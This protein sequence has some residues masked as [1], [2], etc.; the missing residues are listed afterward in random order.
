MAEGLGLDA[1]GN[2]PAYKQCDGFSRRGVFILT[3]LLQ[4]DPIKFVYVMDNLYRAASIDAGEITGSQ[5][6]IILKHMGATDE[7]IRD[8]QMRMRRPSTS[9]VE[10]QS[11][12]PRP[13]GLR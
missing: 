11:Q 8:V 3:H 2:G 7:E 13:P 4:R 5:W 12:Q 10:S 6:K 9:P 1:W